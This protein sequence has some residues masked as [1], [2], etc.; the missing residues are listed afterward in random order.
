MSIICCLKKQ[1]ASR[2]RDSAI[3]Q[4][5]FITTSIHEL[6]EKYDETRAIFLNNSK[7]F[8]TVWRECLLFKSKC[9]GIFRVVCGISVGVFRG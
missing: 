3:Y 5:L 1:S 7:A 9:N 2:P 4:L 6:F 8:D